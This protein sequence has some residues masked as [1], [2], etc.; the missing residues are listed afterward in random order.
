MWSLVGDQSRAIG[1][2]SCGDEASSNDGGDPSRDGGPTKVD[3]EK[4]DA[5]GEAASRAPSAKEHSAMEVLPL[6]V[7]RCNAS[8][9]R[10][11]VTGHGV[12][13]RVAN[14][15]LEAKEASSMPG[16]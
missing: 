9:S 8:C 14:G 6:V 13:D 16:S 10:F 3:K 2:P 4:I 15:E 5:V 11:Q 7:G 1:D 12:G